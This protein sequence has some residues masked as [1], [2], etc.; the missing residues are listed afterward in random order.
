MHAIVINVLAFMMIV[1]IDAI[2][3]IYEFR[4]LNNSWKVALM[5]LHLLNVLCAISFIVIVSS[6]VCFV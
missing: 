5:R 3:T 4:K 2:N 1:C 6:S